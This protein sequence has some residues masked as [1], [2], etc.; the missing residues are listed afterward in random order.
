MIEE[1]L[2]DYLT[3]KQLQQYIKKKHNRHWSKVRVYVLIRNRGLKHYKIGYSNLYKKDEVDEFIST[4]THVS[5][6]GVT[7]K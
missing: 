6:P 4:L 7:A 1:L 2:E 3:T 5:S